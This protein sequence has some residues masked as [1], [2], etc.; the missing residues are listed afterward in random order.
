M[1]QFGRKNWDIKLRQNMWKGADVIF[2]AVGYQNTPYSFGALHEV[3]YVGD[4]QVDS[5]HILGGEL[6]PAVND[7]DIVAALQ[8]HHVLADFTK[9][10]K[11]NDA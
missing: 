10:T 9:A 2:V 1:G 8:C 11:G 4:N 7:Y 5:Q 3:G 6:D